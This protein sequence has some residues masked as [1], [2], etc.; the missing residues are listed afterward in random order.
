[1]DRIWR[2]M[3]NI[4]AAHG[5]DLTDRPPR[6]ITLF[7]GEP[8]LAESRPLIDYMMKKASET[9]GANFNAVSN[10]T[11]LHAYRDVL[12]PGGIGAIQVTL[13]GPPE[14]HDQ[15]RI[16]ADGSGS[17]ERIAENVTMA[18]ERGTVISARMNIDRNNVGRLPALA[19]EFERR[20][21]DRSPLFSAYVAAVHAHNENVEKGSTLDSWQLG[22]AIAGLQ[23]EFPAMALIN[24]PDDGLLQRVRGLFE[25][26]ADP[27]PLLKSS[28][29]GAHT[30][31]YVI[32]AFADIYACW[33]RT[34]DAKMRIGAIAEDGEVRMNSALFNMW[35]RR[36]VTTNPV[37]RSCRY[38]TYCGGGC[39]IYAGEQHGGD[40]FTN[41]CDG[42]GKRFRD[43]VA[44]A[45]GDFV[46]GAP[47][48][49]VPESVCDM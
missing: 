43:S 20:G 26:R 49:P 15:R 39:A 29:C 38:N 36:N 14:E 17:F 9:G 22:Q 13:D 35:R 10:C 7:G 19:A 46:S 34:G 30:S 37:C 28:F 18:L 24:K 31:M 4:D 32:D 6:N 1:V 33:E 3:D 21:W 8:L 41:F 40:M 2:G 44:R 48:R 47:A 16:Y 45:Y 11:D 5:I 12:G 27:M 25:R 42:F 23:E